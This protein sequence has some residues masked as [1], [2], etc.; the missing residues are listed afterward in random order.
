MREYVPLNASVSNGDEL[1]LLTKGQISAELCAEFCYKDFDLVC[2]SISSDIGFQFST[3]FH[4]CNSD[5]SE[6]SFTYR[7]SLL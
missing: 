5:A 7:S 2:V 3:G 4:I 6:T 1:E